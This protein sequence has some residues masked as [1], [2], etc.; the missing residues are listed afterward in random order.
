MTELKLHDT[1]SGFNKSQRG[2][3]PRVLVADIE[4]FP[5]LSYHWR[6]WKQNISDQQVVEDI[7]LMSFAGKWLGQPD[8]FYIDQRGKGAR[9]RDHRKTLRAVHKV[10]SETDFVVA[11]NG[12]RFDL[13]MLQAFMVEAGMAPLPPLKVVD[14]LLLNR[15]QFAFSSQRLGFVSPKF[16]PQDEAKSTHGKFSGFSMWL[17]CMKDNPEAWDENQMYNLRDVTALEELYMKVRGWY[18]GGPNFGPYTHS[19]EEGQH[20]CANCGSTNIKPATRPAYTQVGVY[21][22]HRCG[23]CGAFARGRKLIRTAEQ[24]AHILMN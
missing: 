6:M 21:R 1:A 4:T 17:E 3:G 16:M 10:L 18:K 11:H 12:Q 2:K 23:D 15:K 9:M 19:L 5:M 13:P 8:A 22:Q 20:V 14:T 7:S 24:R